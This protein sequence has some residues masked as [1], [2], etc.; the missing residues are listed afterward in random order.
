MDICLLRTDYYNRPEIVNLSCDYRTLGAA[1]SVN[2]FKKASGVTYLGAPAAAALGFPDHAAAT[3]G[4]AVLEEQNLVVFDEKT[5]EV[6]P[7][8]HAQVNNLNAGFFGAEGT[9]GISLIRSN[10]VRAARQLMEDQKGKEG[11]RVQAWGVSAALITTLAARRLMTS[12]LAIALVLAANETLTRARTGLLN[13]NMLANMTNQ[14]T[15]AAEQ[16]IK[17]VEKL[18]LIKT[19][20]KTGEYVWLK[21]PAVPTGL[22]QEEVAEVGRGLTSKILK[23]HVAKVAAAQLK[24]DFEKLF[25]EMVAKS[26]TSN[27][28]NFSQ[29]HVSSFNSTSPQSTPQGRDKKSDQGD[30]TINPM[31]SDD[32]RKQ[33]IQKLKGGWTEENAGIILTIIQSTC[34]T[35]ERAQRALDVIAAAN[36]SRI[37][38]PAAYWKATARDAELETLPEP[39]KG[40]HLGIDNEESARAESRFSGMT[41]REIERIQELEKQGISCLTPREDLRMEAQNG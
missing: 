10:K 37:K 41:L 5:H 31:M 9:K 12:D 16:G 2:P 34:T 40:R 17:N 13:I 38:Q 6:L 1:C 11:P 21:W 7:T 18:G 26:S 8:D 19:D 28:V 14:L 23:K 20:W 39:V 15:P 29:L 22:T 27:T 25:S 30:K 33:A 24:I 3:K 35:P 4:L 36:V 32:F